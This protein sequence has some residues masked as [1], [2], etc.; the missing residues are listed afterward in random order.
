[1]I[2]KRQKRFTAGIQDVLIDLLALLEHPSAMAELG[3][4]TSC[5]NPRPNPGLLGCQI[6]PHIQITR[7]CCITAYSI[8]HRLYTPDAA[9][10][11]TPYRIL[12]AFLHTRDN[13]Q[14]LVPAGSAIAARNRLSRMS[15]SSMR[16]RTFLH[17]LL[18]P[19]P[20]LTNLH[21]HCRLPCATTNVTIWGGKDKT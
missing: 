19:F 15:V 18:L 5:S 17:N 8:K 7:T 9:R 1:M 13:N 21:L 12:F 3:Q 16:T 2:C 11:H 6:E 4:L 14:T 20:G 10:L